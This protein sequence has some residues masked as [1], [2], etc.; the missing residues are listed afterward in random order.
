[1]GKTKKHWANE[2]A[3]ERPP[4][5]LKVYELAEQVR[6]QDK[7]LTEALERITVLEDELKALRNHVS[8]HLIEDHGQQHK[9]LR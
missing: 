6:R 2:M 9:D 1:M 7:Y 8:D 3:T 5:S 4:L